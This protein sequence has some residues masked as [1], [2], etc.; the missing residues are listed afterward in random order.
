[1]TA[2]ELRQVNPNLDDEDIAEAIDYAKL[3]GKQAREILSS[4]IFQAGLKAK[5]DAKAAEA[6]RPGADH[7]AGGEVKGNTKDL[8]DPSKVD[9]M[10]LGEF[11]KLSNEA[12]KGSGLTIV[13][14]NV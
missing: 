10:P 8:E 7:R 2:M 3:K 4:P 9:K 5:S 12:G 13:P 14:P 11:E 6:A 1:M